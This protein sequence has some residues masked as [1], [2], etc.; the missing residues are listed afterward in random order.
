MTGRMRALVWHGD[1]SFDIAEVPRPTVPQGWVLL[2]VVYTGVCGTDLHI[3]A[4]EHPRARPGLVIGHELIGRVHA[5]GS[6]FAA[7]EAVAVNP[8]LSCGHCTQCRTGMSHRCQHLRLIGIDCDGGIAEQV[9][10]PADALV[11]VDQNADLV[12]LGF[13]EPLAVAVHAMN[14]ARMKL[15]D[16]VG[17][18]GAGPVGLAI[19]LCARQAGA[20][21]VVIREPVPSRRNAARSLGFEMADENVE[22][23][24]DVLFDAAARPEVAA[25]M[26]RWISNGGRIVVVGT[27][28]SPALIDL[29]SVTFGE[30][31][32]VG[33]RL[34]AQE[35]LEEAARLVASGEVDPSPVITNVVSLDD[36]VAAMKGLYAGEGIKVLVEGGAV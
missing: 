5:G 13:V 26:T 9:A 15:G 10:V 36:A 32:I 4:G 18:V 31:E 3:C 33:T 23:D 12:K 19:A 22:V 7:G 27:Y 16:T 24:V 29:Q 21:Q 17:V 34:Y 28:S 6:R 25:S 8:I 35:D 14:Q 2:D 1:N 11:R 20:A 30:L